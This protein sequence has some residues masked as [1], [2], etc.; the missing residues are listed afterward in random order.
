MM[1]LQLSHI[2][3]IAVFVSL[4]GF[5]LP[6]YA[7]A[8]KSKSVDFEQ[9]TFELVPGQSQSLRG[10][11]AVVTC[12]DGTAVLG[13]LLDFS[14]SRDGSWNIIAAPGAAAGDS[15]TIEKSHIVSKHFKLKGTWDDPIGRGNSVACFDSAIPASVVI[16]GQCGLGVTVTLKA[17]NGVTGTFRGD[18][19]CST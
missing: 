14:A 7:I 2:A 1:T 11:D 16:Q 9:Y 18:V 8:N 19:T 10:V 6:T 5:F 15:G 4:L 3:M 12:A 17:S 13:P